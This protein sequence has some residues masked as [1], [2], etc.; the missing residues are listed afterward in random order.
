MTKHFNNLSLVNCRLFETPLGCTLTIEYEK[1]EWQEAIHCHIRFH[2]RYSL[3]PM[4]PVVMTRD[5]RMQTNFVFQDVGEIVAIEIQLMSNKK[6]GLNIKWIEINIPK[7]G[8]WQKF[9]VQRWLHPN[10]GDGRTRLILTPNRIPGYEPKKMLKNIEQP[11]RDHVK[12]MILVKISK[13]NE[14]IDGSILSLDL[15]G[16]SYI[17]E[18]GRTGLHQLN[19][20]YDRIIPLKVDTQPNLFELTMLDIGLL[21]DYEIN[22]ENTEHDGAY[23]VSTIYIFCKQYYEIDVHHWIENTQTLRGHIR[24]LDTPIGSSLFNKI[25]LNSS[26]ILW[27]I[28]SKLKKNEITLPIHFQFNCQ[29]TLINPI[30][31]TV[32]I[33]SNSISV[34]AISTPCAMPLNSILLEYHRNTINYCL[35]KEIIVLDV[36]QG[37]YFYFQYNN[38][39]VK[40]SNKMD[41]YSFLPKHDDLLPSQQ[42][43]KPYVISILTSAKNLSRKHAIKIVLRGEQGLTNMLSLHNSSWNEFPFERKHKDKFVVLGTDI[44]KIIGLTMFHSSEETKYSFDIL[45]IFVPDSKTCIRLHGKYDIF[46]EIIDFNCH[47]PAVVYIVQIKTGFGTLN[48]T[49]DIILTLVGEESSSEW[50]LLTCDSDMKPFRTNELDTF[51]IP[52]KK[53]GKIR[54]VDISCSNIDMNCKWFCEMIIVHDTVFNIKSSFLINRWWGDHQEIDFVDASNTISKT[55]LIQ[56]ASTKLLITFLLTIKTGIRP[57]MNPMLSPSIY[58]FFAG[59]FGSSPVLHLNELTDRIDLFQS[60]EIDEFTFTIPDTGTPTIMR[61]WNT[62]DLA[63]WTCD[64]IDIKYISNSTIT[65][66]PMGVDLQKSNPL[67]SSYIDLEVDVGRVILPLAGPRDDSAYPS[68]EMIIRTDQIKY[69]EDGSIIIQIEGDK[70]RSKR[71]LLIENSNSSSTKNEGTS[72]FFIYGLCSLGD[73]K[74]ISI[75]LK[76]TQRHI[77]WKWEYIIIYDYLNDRYYGTKANQN[78]Y[79]GKYKIGRLN[80]FDTDHIHEELDRIQNESIVDNVPESDPIYRILYRTQPNMLTNVSRNGQIL[81]RLSGDESTAF[82]LLDHTRQLTSGSINEYFYHGNDYIHGLNKIDVQ[83][84]DDENTRWACESIEIYDLKTN[85]IITFPINSL[86]ESKKMT[87]WK[88]GVKSPMIY[89]ICIRTGLQGASLN[90]R[91]GSAHASL[92]LYGDSGVSNEIPLHIPSEQSFYL[93]ANQIDTFEINEMISIVGQ[94]SSIDLYHNGQKEDFWDIQW[95]NIKDEIFVCSFTIS[96][97]LN[98]NI[99]TNLKILHVPVDVSARKSMNQLGSISNYIIRVKT[100]VQTPL[101]SDEPNVVSVVLIDP[102]NDSTRIPLAQSD[103]STSSMFQAEQEDRFEI[104]ITPMLELK[105][106][107]LYFHGTFPWFCERIIVTDQISGLFDVEQWFTQITNDN[108]V[109]IYGQREDDIGWTY[110]VTVKTQAVL[111]AQ[112]NLRGK[113]ILSIYGQNSSLNNAILGSG[114]LMYGLFHAGSEDT[115]ELKSTKRLGDIHS[116]DLRLE[117]SEWQSWFCDTIEII[118]SAA[119]WEFSSRSMISKTYKFPI[120]RWL[121]AHAMDKRTIIHSTINQEPGYAKM[122]SYIVHIL[123][124]TKNM[125]TESNIQA[126]VYLQLFCTIS[127]HVYGP[128]LLDKSSNNTQPFRKGQIDEFYINDLSYCGEIKKIRLWHDGDK[129]T[130]WHC[131]WIKITHVQRNEI[132]EFVVEKILDEDL[133]EG[134]SNLI[135]YSKKKDDTNENELLTPPRTLIS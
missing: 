3:S 98:K 40:S 99:G 69:I 75:D 66:F 41:C 60:L 95:M 97:C 108:P 109:N 29:N 105:I 8:V 7:K 114:R 16:N 52:T 25:P 19:V 84:I 112:T 24:V 36:F 76:K 68:Y 73:L 94:I 56:P 21:N 49:A 132:Y 88:S 92:K 14:N 82:F 116:I 44:G 12:Y 83:L 81:L 86:I 120:N 123:T 80:N 33:R 18:Y 42:H 107:Q 5:G 64:Y 13:T 126:N 89:F 22:L 17:E 110:S 91:F 106:I 90:F 72:R 62:E 31:E 77:K 43:S 119:I 125:I 30:E 57:A 37:Q 48:D 121:G 65:H 78:H 93:R 51:Y 20:K 103:N 39:S 118:D 104:T 74:E 87:T 113:I 46:N 54:S 4:F 100:G 58:I 101:H 124:G 47:E 96:K 128:I 134:S 133:E 15:I 127:N 53:L 79:I 115:I 59:Q 129:S 71:V 26:F 70:N 55:T 111:P 27:L 63:T 45:E 1:I 11:K 6:V 85:D 61:I 135:L 38:E 28:G 35:I 23:F 122:P 10:M 34:L 32:T 9:D 50:I 131:E 102:L 117:V 67:F 2:G 130:S